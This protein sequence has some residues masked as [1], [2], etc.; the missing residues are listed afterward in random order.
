MYEHINPNFNQYEK[1]KILKND[2]RHKIT[3]RMESQLS[4][5]S[6]YWKYLNKTERQ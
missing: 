2:I 5:I 6:F 3:D 1:S 4:E